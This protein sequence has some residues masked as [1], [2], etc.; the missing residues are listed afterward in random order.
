[1]PERTVDAVH[2]PDAEAVVPRT[3]RSGPSNPVQFSDGP[4]TWAETHV[5]A[6]SAVVWDAV[7]DINLPARFSQEFLGAEW[8]GE[9]IGV[10]SSFVG[11]NHHPAIG[12][13]ELKCIVDSFEREQV[14][15]WATADIDKPGARWLFRLRP[16][17]DGTLL[18]FEVSIGPG[19]SGTTAAIEAMPDKESRI[20]RRRIGELHANMTL[21][22][23]GIR[24][25]LERGQQ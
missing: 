18:R 14:F 11:R 21:T 19:P 20:I 25:M 9:H 4:G 15:G 24:E 10:G 12:E 5:A 1:M 7:V 13:W 16:D 23:V 8:D 2:L 22:V 6:S 3:F 17:R